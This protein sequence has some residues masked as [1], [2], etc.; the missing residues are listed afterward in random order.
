MEAPVWTQEM[1]VGVARIDAQHQELFEAAGRMLAALKGQNP[2]PELRETLAFLRRYTLRHFAAEEAAL[3][4]SGYPGLMEHRAV[5]AAL[6]IGFLEV[7]A[8]AAQ[9]GV[10][11]ESLGIEAFIR[12]VVAHIETSDAAYAPHLAPRKPAK[13]CAS[14]ETTAPFSLGFPSVDQDH[15]SFLVFLGDLQEVVNTGRG[16]TEL[17]GLLER[18]QQ[19]AKDHFHREELLMDLLDYPARASHKEAHARFLVGLQ[20]LTKR[21][22]DNRP[23]QAREALEFATHYLKEHLAKEDL[24]LVPFLKGLGR[25]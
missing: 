25:L 7:E 11:S 13:P 5:H 21:R 9:T 6:S 3:Q 1:S 23:E 12:S 19:Y 10:A 24:A 16:E 22:H 18:F 17:D 8:R 20:D 15:A 2:E 14:P 4:A